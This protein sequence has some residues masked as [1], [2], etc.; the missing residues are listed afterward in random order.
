MRICCV[1]GVLISMDLPAFGLCM[2]SS[3][4]VLKMQS[5]KRIVAFN[6]LILFMTVCFWQYVMV[7]RKNALSLID[8]KYCFKESELL[9]IPKCAQTKQ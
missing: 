1:V 5:L 7:K 4:S 9:E 2:H 6:L 3:L 8:L